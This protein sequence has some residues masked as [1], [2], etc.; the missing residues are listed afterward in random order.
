MARKTKEPE[1]VPESQ[2][3]AVESVNAQQVQSDGMLIDWVPPES[4][5]P[6]IRNPRKNDAAVPLV[7][8]SLKEFGWRQ[9]IV[10]DA[11]L[12]IIVGHTRWLAA[13][14]L[15]M[16]KVPIHIARH[17]TEQ[18]VKAYRLTDNRV[19]E[20]ADWDNEL[21]S[22]ELQELEKDQFDMALLGFNAGELAGLLSF[23]GAPV[24]V[25]A[26]WQG[27]P[28]FAQED[29]T[30]FQSIIMHF[31]DADAVEKFA[32]LLRR[33]ITSKTQYLWFPA[34]EIERTAGRSY[35]P[36]TQGESDAP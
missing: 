4:I 10:V 7:A 21:L 26:E 22:L 16:A 29:K 20:E 17:L 27:M 15:K 25:D 13:L 34:Q 36:A 2:P 24:D 14:S 23:T 12:T 28:E 11:D 18:Q 1:K 8:A 32:K 6:Y 19:G 5:T 33:N 30:A 3:A 9:P 31:P 35:S